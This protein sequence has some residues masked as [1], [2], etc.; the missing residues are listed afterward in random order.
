MIAQKLSEVKVK[1][2]LKKYKNLFYAFTLLLIF[3]MINFVKPIKGGVCYG[4]KDLPACKI[5]D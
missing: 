5:N 3:Y 1:V 2:C 4:Y